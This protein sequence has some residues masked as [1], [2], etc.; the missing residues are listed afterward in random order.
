MVVSLS[1]A[2]SL[3][4][5]SSCFTIPLEACRYTSSTPMQAS[6]EEFAS[7]QLLYNLAVCRGF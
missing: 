7:V 2:S 6:T 1:P 5:S 4:P 3:Q